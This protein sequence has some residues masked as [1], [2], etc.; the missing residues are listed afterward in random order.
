MSSL[1]CLH[2]H[3]LVNHFK[4]TTALPTGH[5][6]IIIRLVIIALLLIF[7]LSNHIRVG[8]VLHPCLEVPHDVLVVETAQVGHLSTDALVFLRVQFATQLYLLDSIDI[9]IESVSSLI[10]RSKATLP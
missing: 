9:T 4:T 6:L 8:L 7:E 2:I 3:R 1:A 5:R 10:D